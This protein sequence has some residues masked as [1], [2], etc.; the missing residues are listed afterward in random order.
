MISL[1]VES[2][3]KWYIWTYLQNSN[4]LRRQTYGY[5]RAK[6]EGDKLRD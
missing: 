2:K 6:V 4:R 1:N 3:K 5:Q